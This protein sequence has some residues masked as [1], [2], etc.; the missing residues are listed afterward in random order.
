[1]KQLNGLTEMEKIFMKSLISGMYAEAGFSDQDINDIQKDTGLSNKVS[2]G[3]LGSL[4]KKGFLSA[5]DNGE[6]VIIYIN[7]SYYGLVPHWAEYEGVE[8]IEIV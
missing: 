1:M 8:P 4:I 5:D 7:Q 2:R 3:V 6:Y